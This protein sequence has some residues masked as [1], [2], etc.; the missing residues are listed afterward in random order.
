LKLRI[1]HTNDTHGSLSGPKLPHLRQLRSKADL[2][3]DSGDCIKAGN[4]GVPLRQEAA[5]GILRDLGCDAGVLGNRETHPLEPA[6]KAKIAGVAHPLLCA[7]LRFK[8]GT[9]PLPQSLVLDIR[10]MKIGLIGVMVPM[11]TERMKTKAASA[12]IWDP[13]IPIAAELAKELRPKVDLL[14]ALTHTGHKEDLKLAEQVPL[15]DAILGGHSHTVLPEP[16]Y[17]GK[18]A[19]CQG[20][21]HMRFAGMY[22]WST[23]GGWLGGLVELGTT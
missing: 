3:F 11:V 12:Y 19:V 16:V 18:T 8:D 20:G 9:R 14:I 21:S 5:W 17:V 2:Y 23:D 15:F 4:L 1:L 7:N 22:E 10:D 13:P 6:F